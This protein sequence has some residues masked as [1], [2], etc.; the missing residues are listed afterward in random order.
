MWAGSRGI[1][2]GRS[3][4]LRNSRPGG[5]RSDRCAWRAS[6]RGGANCIL[7]AAGK[8]RLG[9]IPPALW[10]GYD[11]TLLMDAPAATLLFARVRAMFP[12][13]PGAFIRVV[14]R[15]QLPALGLHPAP[16]AAGLRLRLVG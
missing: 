14:P 9:R 4:P 11:A 15:A 8:Y 5:R 2:W 6:S 12:A 10:C 1:A 3:T 16:A 7:I 13:W